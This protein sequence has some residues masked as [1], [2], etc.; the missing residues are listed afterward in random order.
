MQGEFWIK[1]KVENRSQSGAALIDTI[2]IKR[3]LTVSDYPTKPQRHSGNSQLVFSY[4]VMC[5]KNYCGSN[6]S[7]CIGSEINT[8]NDQ[9]MDNVTN[10]TN[11]GIYIYTSIPWA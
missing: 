6:C 5:A 1:I 8:T 9:G 10:N 2:V 3:N 11:K 7:T 4:Q